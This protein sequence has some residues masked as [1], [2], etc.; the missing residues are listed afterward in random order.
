MPKVKYALI[1]QRVIDSCIRNPYRPYPT[2]EDLRL[3]CEEK[4]YGEGAE[5]EISPSTIEKDLFALREEYEAPIAFSKKYKGYYYTDIGFSLDEFPLNEEEV[6]AIKFAA[7]TLFQFRNTPIFKSYSAAIEK[8]ID[9]VNISS[10]VQDEAI[11]KYV[12]FQANPYFKGNQ[13]LSQLLEA[14]KA[15]KQ[16][17][18]SYSNFQKQETKTYQLHPYLLKEYAGR[19]YLIGFSEKRNNYLT[20]GLDRFESMK[21]LNQGFELDKKF[22]SDNFF[23]HS[24][25]ITVFDDEPQE[26]ILKL[27]PVEGK[28]LKSLPLHPSQKILVDND[29]EC[30]ISLFLIVTQELIMKILSLGIGVEVIQPESLRKEITAIFSK[31][32]AQYKK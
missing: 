24:L 6:D 5:G 32:L 12:Q 21:I 23:K 27:S 1:R 31:S 9:R 7:N 29:N 8:I 22:D 17:E 14:I 20:F 25:G 11:G 16:V 3:A 26:I 30:R 10:D 13:Y 4:L 19:W 15:R 28:Y 2:K 18:F